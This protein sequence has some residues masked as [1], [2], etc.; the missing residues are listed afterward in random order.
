MLFVFFQIL[1][2]EVLEVTNVLR[3]PE[4]EYEQVR[5]VI[6]GFLVIED[7]KLYKDKSIELPKY[8]SGKGYK[9]EQVDILDEAL[10]DNIVNAILNDTDTPKAVV[11]EKKVMISFAPIEDLQ[12]DSMRKA[13]VRVI[14]GEQIA[15]IC[16]IMKSEKGLWIA[17]PS[18]KDIEGYYYDVVYILPKKLKKKV[19]QKILDKYN[20]K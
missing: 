13:N 4:N 18:I 6:G 12:I 15:V 3:I 20:K 14:L 17:W 1:C 19:E 5:I 7:I 9:Y 2:A 11:N 8:V 16:G 10:E